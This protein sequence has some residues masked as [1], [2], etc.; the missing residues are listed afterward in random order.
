VFAAG[1]DDVDLA[2]QAA[3]KAL[4]DPS[5]KDLPPAERGKLIFRLSELVE[6]HA[7][8]LATIETWDNGAAVP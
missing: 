2:V 4:K 8:I 7:E 6:Q 3:R 5:W 1:P